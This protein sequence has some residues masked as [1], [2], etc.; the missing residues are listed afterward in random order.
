M[1]QKVLIRFVN[2]KLHVGLCDVRQAYLLHPT[3]LQLKPEVYKG[4]L[5]YR[6]P[7]TSRRISY[8]QVKKGLLKKDLWLRWQVP[9][10]V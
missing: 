1:E 7:G 8:N 2:E 10:W 3:V 4:R 6:I 9:S 5:V